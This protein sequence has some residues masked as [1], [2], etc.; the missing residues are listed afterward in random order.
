MSAI[1][2][3]IESIVPRKAH[4]FGGKAKNLAALARAG[5]P[6]PAAYA[7]EA[8]AAEAFFGAA[9]P[10]SDQPAALLAAPSSL[11]T[12]ERLAELAERARSAPVPPGVRGALHEALTALRREGAVAVAV[13]SSSTREDQEATSAAGLHETVL[14]VRTEDELVDAVRACWVSLL[15]PHAIRYLRALPSGEGPA[16][17]IGVVIQAMVPAEVA[18]AM[19][20]V[21]PLSGDPGEMVINAAYGL[22]STVMDGRVSPDTYR[23]DKATG[24]VR[25]RVVGDKAI[26]ARWVPDRGVLEE[27]VPEAQ[28][29]QPSLGEDLLE[30]LVD[31]GLRVEEHFDDAR[32]VEWAAVGGTLYL[33]QAR[34]VTALTVA[35]RRRSPR[36]P[37]EERDRSR[38]VW[39]N[40]NVG[41]AL[42]GVATPL[43]W[44]VLSDFSERGFRRAF[45][46][47]GCTVPRDAELV[48]SFRGRI[49]LN[50]TEF[51]EI[52][53]Q[54]PGLRPKTLLALGGGG[55]VERLETQVEAKGSTGFL[56]RLPLTVARYLR[57]NVGLTE[58]VQRF[59]K[60]FAEEHRRL[61]SVDFRVLSSSGLDRVLF[62]VERLLDDSGQVML[63]A[64]GNLLAT[65][66]LL[67]A[68]L[69][70]VA[71]GDAERLERELLTG[72]ADVE[73]AAPGLALWHIAEMARGEEA[74][75]DVLADQDPDE[76]RVE[77]LPPGPT[78]RALERFLTAYGYR[79]AREAEIA[80]ARWAEDPGLLFATLRAHLTRPAGGPSPVDLERRQREVRDRASEELERR[81]PLPA[82]MA[83]RHLLS[84]VQ[85]FMRL[86]ERLRSHVVQVLGLYRAVALDASRR[87]RVL[88]PGAGSDGAFYLSIP[89]LHAFLRGDAESLAPIVKRRRLQ[90]ER[91][92]A[93]PDPPDSFAGFPPPVE[94]P[95]ET[96]DLLTGL[97]ACSG[98]VRGS[99]RVL[100]DAHDASTLEPGEILVAPWADV[101]WSPLFLVAAGVVTDL[102][103]PLSHAAVVAREYGVPT[104]VNVKVGTKV[105][106]TG[107]EV[108]VDGG[109][110]TVRILARVDRPAARANAG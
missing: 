9:L 20:T 95:D 71:R 35:P 84:L 34:P 13:R 88:E 81:L 82:R 29:A 58:R 93:L 24:W 33:L 43:T 21:N 41:E 74:A 101:G 98:V 47:L 27:P 67:R 4:A 79:G 92:R 99:A 90:L 104:V 36:R 87:L 77:D 51:M 64:Y 85:R 52:A 57:E 54:V 110:G 46:A 66:V 78:R 55:E 61:T 45:G 63:N 39:S 68:V 91:D 106:H 15:S 31:L 12:D 37:S 18:G 75:R 11:I 22:G 32:D 83:V 59:E 56:L 48:A 23:V 108:E 2:R 7:L 1:V 30:A 40:V 26:A 73:S 42:P 53:S 50:M 96:A 49:Y 72:L 65:V 76:L 86:R 109:A 16:A 62:R 8:S 38:L 19:F 28:R 14:G 105:I 80:E 10:A 103:G 60:A 6:V 5:F 25:D 3:R 100:R 97:A 44:S 94:A 102:G 107:D 69:G 17:G 89:E 70:T